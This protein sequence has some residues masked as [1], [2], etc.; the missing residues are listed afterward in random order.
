MKYEKTPAEEY[1]LPIIGRVYC[2][3]TGSIGEETL[4]SPV[5]EFDV[6]KVIDHGDRQTYIC[7][8][9]NS[10]GVVQM[11]P[12]VCVIKYEEF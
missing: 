10:P 4:N 6:I 2:K 1:N 7:N 8:H 9:W 11:V 12:D 3:L 5:D